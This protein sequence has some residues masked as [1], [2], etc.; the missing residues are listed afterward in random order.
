M[1]TLFPLRQE[2]QK[3]FEAFEK[4]LVEK[5]TSE[6]PESWR[7]FIS[8]AEIQAT[9]NAISDFCRSGMF[10]EHLAEDNGE[11]VGFIT[12]DEKISAILNINH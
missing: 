8:A 5:L 10:D 4:K 3:A 2:K 11:K 9:V 12:S 6:E 7:Y 1:E